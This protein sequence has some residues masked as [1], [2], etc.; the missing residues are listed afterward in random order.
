MNWDWK[1]TEKEQKLVEDNLKLATDVIN[2]RFNRVYDVERSDLIQ[3]AN[4]GLIWAAHF[5]VKRGMRI[6]FS[7]FAWCRIVVFVSRELNTRKNSG[8]LVRMVK[9]LKRQFY[10][11]RGRELSLREVGIVFELPE[12]VIRETLNEYRRVCSLDEVMEHE[13]DSVPFV[14]DRLSPLNLVI[15]KEEHL[16]NEAK[17]VLKRI[18]KMKALRELL[19]SQ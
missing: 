4:L 17:S 5:F 15:L 11:L 19:Q 10:L 14:D 16:N 12:K 3:M 6:N 1:L 8:N 7:T 13:A 9:K 18:K 2:K